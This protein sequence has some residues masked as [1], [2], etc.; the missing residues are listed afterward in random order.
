[1]NCLTCR[2]EAG[3][4]HPAE[5]VCRSCGAAVCGDH[6]RIV[7]QERTVPMGLG[8]SRVRTVAAVHCTGC[9]H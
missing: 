2:T 7:R 9:R 1:M 3:H 8:T 5:G 6:L 4:T